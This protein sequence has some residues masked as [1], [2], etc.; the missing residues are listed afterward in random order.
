MAILHCLA[1]QLSNN[2]ISTLTGQLNSLQKRYRS[3]ED[4]LSKKRAELRELLRQESS[5]ASIAAPPPSASPG[6]SPSGG[7][8]GG[9]IQIIPG[10]PSSSQSASGRHPHPH[11]PVPGTS[12]PPGPPSGEIMHRGSMMDLITESAEFRHRRERTS[13]LP[14]VIKKLFPGIPE[15]YPVPGCC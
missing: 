13:T 10:I 6:M 3:V 8:G 5:S 15:V 4:E 11:H 1:T 9:K 12:L 2:P 14:K 7:G